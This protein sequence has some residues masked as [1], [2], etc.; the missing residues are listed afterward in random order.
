[1]I[2]VQETGYPWWDMIVVHLHVFDDQ[3][4]PEC[5]VT[6]LVETRKFYIGSALRDNRVDG[7]V[8]HHV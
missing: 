2:D 1:M 7:W 5:V 4:A 8:V 3:I 6:A